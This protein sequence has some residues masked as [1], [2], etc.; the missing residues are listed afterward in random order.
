MIRRM[1]IHSLVAALLV[2]AA[3]FSWQALATRDGAAGTAGALAAVLFGG[4]HD[5]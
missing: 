5:D 4:G 1:M 2:A 3:A